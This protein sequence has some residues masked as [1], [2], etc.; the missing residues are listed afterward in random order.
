MFPALLA[1]TGAAV[2]S[3]VTIL[4]DDT[5]DSMPAAP[6]PFSPISMLPTIWAGFDGSELTA[7]VRGGALYDG[8]AEHGPLVPACSPQD[9]AVRHLSRVRARSR[10]LEWERVHA[11]VLHPIPYGVFE[12]WHASRR[13]LLKGHSGLELAGGLRRG[14]RTMTA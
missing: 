9:L 11:R 3:A 2:D 4:P 6:S 12:R 14:A 13:L 1:C 10:V 7:E 8:C 5:G